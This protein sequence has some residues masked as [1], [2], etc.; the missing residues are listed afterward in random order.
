MFYAYLPKLT[1]Q[2]GYLYVYY[3]KEDQIKHGD[4]T[5]IKLFKIGRTKR[6][7]WLR[8]EEQMKANGEVYVLDSYKHSKYNEFFEKMVSVRM[9]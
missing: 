3:L 2:P 7:P 6:Q 4:K 8:V 1:D 5:K 9:K